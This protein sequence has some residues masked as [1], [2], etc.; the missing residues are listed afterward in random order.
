MTIIH[1]A[2]SHCLLACLAARTLDLEESKA[3][4]FNHPPGEICIETYARMIN[5]FC[6]KAQR[7]VQALLTLHLS[8]VFTD[9]C[10]HLYHIAGLR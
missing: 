8:P 2:S 7:F 9:T 3:V 6:R 1:A 5:G 4:V 10:F